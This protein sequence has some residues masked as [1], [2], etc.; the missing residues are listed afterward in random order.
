M[1]EKTLGQVAFEVRFDDLYTWEEN[2]H[3]TKE[4]WERAAQAVVS[5]SEKYLEDRTAEY[6]QQLKNAG[7]AEERAKIEHVLD[8]TS[9]GWVQRYIDKFKSEGA[10]EERERC[11]RELKAAIGAWPDQNK[12]FGGPSLATVLRAL[13]DYWVKP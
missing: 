8:T 4:A 11:A 7:A 3:G 13:A 12:P 6:G 1:T 2:A 9:D 5:H 10:S